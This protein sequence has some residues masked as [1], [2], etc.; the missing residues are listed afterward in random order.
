LSLF[1]PPSDAATAK[2]CV[3]LL[4]LRPCRTGDAAHGQP[5][6]A[7]GGLFADEAINLLQ[8]FY[9]CGNPT[10]VAPVGSDRRCVL[11]SVNINIWTS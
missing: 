6:E 11:S 8:Q 10:G 5:F 2:T 9:V 4:L 1:R 3:V 7:H